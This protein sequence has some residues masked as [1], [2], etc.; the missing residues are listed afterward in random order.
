MKTVLRLIAAAAV[1]STL[2]AG[3]SSVPVPPR[4]TTDGA[5]ALANL[6]AMVERGVAD[7]GSIDLMLLR[8]QFRADY[9]TLDHVAALTE[10]RSTTAEDL[11]RR[12]KAR[13][14]AH[15][16]VDASADLEAAAAMGAP[17][18]RVQAQRAGLQV[19]CGQA[20]DALP[21]LQAQASR[22]P[23]F[24]TLFALARGEAAAGRLEEADAMYA[25]ALR[26]LDTTSP[27][28]A[29]VT[30]FARGQ[31]WSEQAADATRG[32]AMYREALRLV[33][34]FVGAR[35]HLAEL[36]ASQGRA[37]QAVS[38]L[39][40][41][42]R[43]AREPE[44]LALLGILHTRLGRTGQGQGE[45]DDARARFEDLLRR[46]PQAFADHA[47]EFYLGAGR[48]APR[49]LAWARL[50]FD[51][52]PTRRAHTLLVRALK[53]DGRDDEAQALDARMQAQFDPRAI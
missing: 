13:A 26:N 30:W 52:R 11:M 25:L 33:P 42:T 7:P 36:L 37:A 19:A 28:P 40:P 39:E 2:C 45:I 3:C 16:F 24:G 32:A 50:N 29:A 51:Q 4:P 53:A 47:A 21:W 9:A 8:M 15:R 34:A 43:E 48:D 10:S 35:V 1:A 5:I 27:F 18:A 17:Q 6:D 23:D 12:A 46:H 44:A 38:L 22:R 31:M 20:R 49:A 14:A 41:V